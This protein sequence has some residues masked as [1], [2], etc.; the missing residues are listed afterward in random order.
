MESA[1]L[2]HCESR[3]GGTAWHFSITE[4]RCKYFLEHWQLSACFALKED[5]GRKAD[6]DDCCGYVKTFLGGMAHRLEKSNSESLP[7][8]RP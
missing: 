2:A 5:Y 6:F 7:K 3:S 8:N 1:I 4:P